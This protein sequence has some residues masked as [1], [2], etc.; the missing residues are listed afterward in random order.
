MPGHF[1]TFEGGEGCGKTT[2]VALLAQR[3]SQMGTTVVTTREP[4]GSPLAERLRTLLLQP[5]PHETIEP[6]TELLLMSAARCQHLA[7]KIQP[8]LADGQWV[9]CD[10]FHDSSWVYQGCGRGL[11]PDLIATLNGWVTATTFPDLTF[12]LD[13]D[14]VIGLQRTLQR[15]G[16]Q[17]RFAREGMAFHQRLRQGFLQLAQQHPQRCRLIDAAQSPEQIAEQIWQQLQQAYHGLR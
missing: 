3:L 15:D 14:P 5:S 4:G 2:Q 9:L 6:I 16:N 17:D 10:R 7:H 13:I 1:I 11:A 8:A 12:I